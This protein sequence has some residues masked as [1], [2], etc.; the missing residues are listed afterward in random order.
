MMALADQKKCWLV[1]LESV[2]SDELAYWLAFYELRKEHI[3]RESR[4]HG[5]GR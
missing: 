4:K 1:D 3:D 5:V 2:P